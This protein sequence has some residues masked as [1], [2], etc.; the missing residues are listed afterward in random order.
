MS[1][2][3]CSTVPGSSGHV[4]MTRNVPVS[5]HERPAVAALKCCCHMLPHVATWVCR[6]TAKSPKLSVSALS[7]RGRPFN[8]W[9]QT[10]AIRGG[11]GELDMIQIIT[12]V[13]VGNI[14][15]QTYSKPEKYLKLNAP[16]RKGQKVISGISFGYFACNEKTEEVFN[17]NFS[18]SLNLVPWYVRQ[19]CVDILEF[20]GCSEKIKA[21]GIKSEFSCKLNWYILSPHAP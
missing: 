4:I 20:S 8:F 21:A 19:G 11:R 9:L 10:A 6:V 3:Q 7:V 14:C 1:L 13:S 5:L 16:L 12:A 15:R 18:W 17:E 2:F